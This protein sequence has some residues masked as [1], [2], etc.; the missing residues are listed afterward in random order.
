[1]QQSEALL[2]VVR[3][4]LTD[5]VPADGDLQIKEVKK[6]ITRLSSGTFDIKNEMKKLKESWDNIPAGKNTQTF[7]TW[8]HS[9]ILVFPSERRGTSRPAC[10]NPT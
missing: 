8:V 3:T 2:K 4:K 5:K 1:M 10:C 7:R 9:L 6:I